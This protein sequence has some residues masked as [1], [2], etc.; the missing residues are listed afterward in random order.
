MLLLRRLLNSSC[1]NPVSTMLEEGLVNPPPLDFLTENKISS[2]PNMMMAARGTTRPFEPTAWV[3]LPRT[4][5]HIQIQNV[6]LSTNN[7]EVRHG[8]R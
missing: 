3:P 8:L 6:R 5:P 4:L 1:Q 7:R 2:F